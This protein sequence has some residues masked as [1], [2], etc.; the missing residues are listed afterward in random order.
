MIARWLKI[1]EALERTFV[2]AAAE[3]NLSPTETL[4]ILCGMAARV[5]WRDGVGIDEA[6]RQIRG[7]YKMFEAGGT[8]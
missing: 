8:T 3:F 7:A 6:V 5:A 2:P 4:S 1:A